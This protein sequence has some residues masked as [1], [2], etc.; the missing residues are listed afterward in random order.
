MSM[1]KAFI[2]ALL[3]VVSLNGWA[4]ADAQRLH[5]VAE[6]GRHVMPFDLDKTLHIFDK[7]SH[8]GIQQV[9]A[10][11]AQDRPQIDL[12]RQHLSQLAAH[13]AQGDFS[14]PSQ[15]HGKHMPGLATLAEF[16]RQIGFNY[17][18]LPNGAQIEYVS[19]D[20]ALVD[21]IHRYFN[22]QLSDHA[23]HATS[24]DAASHCPLHDA[25]T[26]IQQQE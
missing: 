25:H 4:A 2:L 15:I 9:V 7:T 18:E 3:S 11:D 8:G 5:S 12:I 23:R 6:R 17:R 16:Y 10:K 1:N 26:S 21:A 13:F 19:E 22:A 24:S 20:S 14:G